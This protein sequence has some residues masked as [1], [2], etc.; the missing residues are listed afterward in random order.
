MSFNTHIQA[1]NRIEKLAQENLHL[2][3]MLISSQHDL[4]I[5]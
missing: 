1:L 3:K 5:L 4:R 2:K